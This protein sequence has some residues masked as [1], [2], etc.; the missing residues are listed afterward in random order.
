MKRL[1]A[2]LLMRDRDALRLL[3]ANLRAGGYEVKTM[4]SGQ[5]ILGRLESGLGDVLVVGEELPDMDGLMLCRRLRENSNLPVV[6]IGGEEGSAGVVAALNAGADDYLGYPYS[7][8]EF[9][10]RVGAVMRRAGREAARVDDGKRRIG[11]LVI[12]VSQRQVIA[13][14]KIAAL[15]PT[16][17]KLLVYLAERPDQVVPHKELLGHVWGQEYIQCVHYLRVG[18]G[19]LRQKIEKDP[20]NPIYLVTCSGVGYMLQENAGGK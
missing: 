2:A 11:N 19:R 9:F 10:A 16:E 6:M 20:A 13:K 18:I 15:T 3:R 4:R 17:F 1:E 5:E 7:T 14:G 12:D 8:D